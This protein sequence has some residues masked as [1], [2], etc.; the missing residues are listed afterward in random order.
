MGH[1]E[2]FFCLFSHFQLG[3]KEAG[4]Y[5]TTDTATMCFV[6]EICRSVRCF[7]LRGSLLSM[8]TT[9]KAP[10]GP[11]GV[12]S[13]SKHPFA[14]I[15]LYCTLRLRIC[16][17]FFARRVCLCGVDEKTT[18]TSVHTVHTCT[19]MIPPP[20]ILVALAHPLTSAHSLSRPPGTRALAHSLSH[21]PGTRA[22]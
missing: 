2:F 3:W 19:L 7:L 14:C 9:T 21:P 18:S 11:A 22:L 6:V 4:G 12:Q 16:V 8:C 17:F 20:P 5:K 15:R 10:V 13:S 1:V